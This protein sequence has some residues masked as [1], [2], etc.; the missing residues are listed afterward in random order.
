MNDVSGWYERQRTAT[1]T[2]DPEDDRAEERRLFLGF[3][4][5]VAFIISM[6]VVIS[7]SLW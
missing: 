3:G 2:D 6:L 7:V 4:I 5:G 1:R